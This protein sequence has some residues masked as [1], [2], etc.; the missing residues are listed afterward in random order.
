MTHKSK[1]ISSL[2][3]YR[4]SLST[5]SLRGKV[6]K[7]GVTDK[8]FI[9]GPLYI[10][11]LSKLYPPLLR[12]IIPHETLDTR[13]LYSCYPCPFHSF[14]PLTFPVLIH[15]SVASSFLRFKVSPIKHFLNLSQRSNVFS[16]PYKYVIDFGHGTNYLFFFSFSCLKIILVYP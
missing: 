3:V 15:W 8:P 12:S 11:V 10:L 16:F 4:E 14:C 7:L 1:N 2:A 5:P 13:M 6:H 9:M